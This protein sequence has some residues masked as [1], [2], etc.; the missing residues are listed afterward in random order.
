[1]SKKNQ[2]N[3]LV[4]SEIFEIFEKKSS[5]RYGIHLGTID[6]CEEHN[7]IHIRHIDLCYNNYDNPQLSYAR[8]RI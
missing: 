6:L 7:M 3:E 2:H 8:T 4:S 5:I 1:M